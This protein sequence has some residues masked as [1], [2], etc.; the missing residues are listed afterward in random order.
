MLRKVVL[1]HQGQIYNG[2]IRNI[3]TTGALVEGL[4][5]VPVGTIFNIRLSDTCMV[6]ATTR[7]CSQDRMGVEFSV[8]LRR[9][10]SGRIEVVDDDAAARRPLRKAG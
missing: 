9:D 3:S 4:W 2:T 8:P 1:D 7:W 5:N 6:T 10:P